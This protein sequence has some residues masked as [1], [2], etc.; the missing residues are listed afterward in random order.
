M[1]PPYFGGRGDCDG[2]NGAHNDLKDIDVLAALPTAEHDFRLASTRKFFGQLKSLGM[3]VKDPSRQIRSL[4]FSFNL[5]V[6]VET[7][8]FFSKIGDPVDDLSIAWGLI[9]HNAI[10]CLDVQTNLDILKGLAGRPRPETGRKGRRERGRG[11]GR[12]GMWWS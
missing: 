6:K 4:G 9:N 5:T 2:L 3:P 11:G 8:V 10:R 12:G 1:R 7:A